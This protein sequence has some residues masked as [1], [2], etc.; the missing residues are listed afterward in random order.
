MSPRNGKLIKNLLV[1]ATLATVFAAVSPAFAAKCQVAV[2]WT[3]SIRVTRLVQ[4]AIRHR[5]Q[6]TKDQ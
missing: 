3:S 2:A 4:L 6:P 1:G 5:I